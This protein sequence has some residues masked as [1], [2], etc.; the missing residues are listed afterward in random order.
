MKTKKVI[1][2]DIADRNNKDRDFLTKVIVEYV[3]K[4]GFLKVIRNTETN[5]M[6]L[7]RILKNDSSIKFPILLKISN[8]IVDNI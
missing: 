6:T 2:Q 3:K 7:S 8:K 1:I 5:K 4:E